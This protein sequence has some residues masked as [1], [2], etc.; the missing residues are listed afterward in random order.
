MSAQVQIKRREPP[1]TVERQDFIPF[2]DA[3][4][5][6]RMIKAADYWE[7]FVYINP[8]TR[9]GSWFAMCTCGSPAVIIGGAEAAEQETRPEMNLLACYI[10][11]LTLTELGKARHAN[12]GEQVWM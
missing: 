9:K 2:T 5:R 12:Q 7:H 6:W 8:D 1:V 11:T 4:N 3:D 10:Y